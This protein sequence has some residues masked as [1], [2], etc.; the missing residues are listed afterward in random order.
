MK[1]QTLNVIT[2][3][4][5]MV[6]LLLL[7]FGLAVSSV[8]YNT[9]TMDEQGFIVR[10]LAYLRHEHQGIRV[11]HP[12]GLNA[13]NA[14]L[15][16]ADNSV[17]LPTND[18][19][20][21]ATSFH[22]PAELFL[23]EIGNNVPHIMFLARLPTVWL[24][25][26]L[27]AL[28]GRWARSMSRKSWAAP[29]ALLLTALDPNILAHTSLATTDLGLAAAAALAGFTLWCFF[30]QPSWQRA[31][32]AGA[33][34][35]L[36]QNSKFTAALFVPLFGL[37]ILIWLVSWWRS[38]RRGPLLSRYSPLVQ[39]IVAYPLAG[40]LTLWACYGFDISTL[41]DNLP[42]LS[43]LSGLTV[44]LAHHLEQLLDIGG[45]L[46]VSTPSFLNGRYSDQGWWYYFPAAFFFKTPL[47]TLLLLLWAALKAPTRFHKAPFH[48]AFL[49]IPPLGYLAIGMTS[50]INLGYRHLLPMLPFLYVFIAATLIPT[51]T[52]RLA[53]LAPFLLAWLTIVSLLISPHFLAFFNLLA[54]GPENGWH[55][56]VDS[57]LDWG[58]D[59]A[60]L[61]DWMTQNDIAHIWLS[62]FG[63]ARP[64]YYGLDYTGLDSF[65]PRL[66]N[67]QARP[68]FPADPAPGYYAISATNL[69]GVLFQNHDLF[70][71]F[72][73]KRPLTKIG[74]SIFIY[75]VPAYGQPTTLALS[76]L[77]LDQIHPA[78]FALL[79]TNQVTPLWFEADQSLLAASDWL[80]LN[81]EMRLDPLLD[82]LFQAASP[83][84][85]A[86]T[87][88]YTLYQMDW[89]AVFTDTFQ[90]TYSP[91]TINASFSQGQGQIDLTQSATQTIAPEPGGELVLMTVWKQQSQPQPVKI[92]IHLAGEDGTP[93]SQWDGL[94]LA[95]EVWRKGHTLYQL[96]HLS[97]PEELSSGTYQL[98][99]GL[100]Q[101]QTLERWTTVGTPDGRVPLGQITITNDE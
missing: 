89:T 27:A 16:V 75:E 8:T 12:L 28:V 38:Q 60:G 25:M 90:T 7:Q 94:G 87:A 46:Q 59:L 82:P 84:L 2:P 39:L 86:Q 73:E 21:Q 64:E 81:H 49:F 9:P 14:A 53:F 31:I 76:G 92:F 36:L 42:T 67:P 19:S 29:V 65:P 5:L 41:P 80:L 93:I 77:Q 83:T 20:W 98:W 61:K 62:Y 45:R 17:S 72:R 97:L 88:D 54:G 35:G 47:P 50:S 34:F 70:G 51:L 79:G 52:F 55:H 26:L 57:N 101:P 43:Q 48:L 4:W 23:W 71:W 44:P 100:Y 24:G 74:Y 15:L 3:Q 56:L 11:G 18:P 96:H 30:Q 1:N 78:D 95:W 99:V 33:A 85:A 40:L 91:H 63:E 32:I 66:M 37:L 58:Q 6:A 13:L 22:R 69:Q 68:F 10:G